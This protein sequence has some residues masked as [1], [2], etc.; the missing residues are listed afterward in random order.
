MTPVIQYT[1]LT[2]ADKL[3]DRFITSQVYRP[4]DPDSQ[5]EGVI[6]SQIEILNPWLPATQIGQTIINTAIREYYR[7]GDTSELNNF[8]IA[9][10]K[11]NET[12][13]Q[14][15]QSGETEWIGRLN[16]VLILINNQDI[17]ISQTGLTQAYLFRSGKVNHVTEGIINSAEPHPLKTFSNI[18]SGTLDL[19]DRII[20]ANPVVFE[21]VPL[22]RIKEIVASAAPALAAE[23]LAKLLRR[24]KKMAGE[25][26]ILELT[27]KDEVASMPPEYKIDTVYIDRKAAFSLGQ[28]KDATLK[29]SGPLFGAV[30]T[31]AGRA[32]KKADFHFDKHIVPAVTKVSARAYHLT[33]KAAT[34]AYS[35]V[36]G[37]KIHHHS[38]NTQLP[39]GNEGNQKPK[40]LSPASAAKIA[41]PIRSFGS[42]AGNWLKEKLSFSRDGGANKS[43][44][45]GIWG[46]ALLIVLAILVIVSWHPGSR[47]QT[48]GN[49][50]ALTSEL[51]DK[52]NRVKLLSA[53]NDK[54][55]A[56]KELADIIGQLQK[57]EKDQTLTPSL[58]ELKK[59]AV[60]ELASLTNSIQLNNISNLVEWGDKQFIA[61]VDSQ[62][63]VANDEKLTVLPANDTALA[64]VGKMAALSSDKDNKLIYILGSSNMW[65]FNPKDAS[66]SQVTLT[67]GSWPAAK[68]FSIFGGNIYALDATGN[69]IL[70]YTPKESGFAA[71][72][73]Y[74]QPEGS[75]LNSAIDMAI[76]GA[77]MTLMNDA[78]VIKYTKT[79]RTPVTITELPAEGFITAP[80]RIYADSDSP[81]I[82]I[83]H[84]DFLVKGMSRL[85][86]FT[87]TGKYK[88]SVILPLDR[89]TVLNADLDLK[90]GQATIVTDKIVYQANTNSG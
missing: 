80:R 71:G 43:R 81:D 50:D 46:V 40:V 42:T 58:T 82:A 89:G 62:V 52:F 87:K 21:T 16:G 18:M 47:Q 44:A 13:A 37:Q 19:H 11:V 53:Y 38:E 70:K 69:K 10:K 28:L 30:I 27:T 39:H 9:L 12:L 29:V 49:P 63:V 5:R 84:D 75:E 67:E 74:S 23:E 8:E 77:V 34:G 88:R 33:R 24:E 22:E 7:A 31:G 68:Q 86:I 60:N 48:V 90:T 41:S 55:S 59:Q 79:G 35:R 4:A 78:R 25:A 36:R 32:L 45:Y 17:H 72:I 56:L 6:F 73:S 15:T 85:S 61:S 3:P 26:L 65:R 14:I 66:L 57:V 64:G 83:L 1:R 20:I 54:P 51:G 76:N 2:H